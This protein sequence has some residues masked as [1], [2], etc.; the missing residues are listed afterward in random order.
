MAE[1]THGTS[2]LPDGCL[3]QGPTNS[4]RRGLV[5]SSFMEADV[6]M[7]IARLKIVAINAAATKKLRLGHG[8]C[9][10]S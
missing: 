4:N 9:K 8:S 3:S 10:G 5:A 7:V 6:D 2:P 1:T